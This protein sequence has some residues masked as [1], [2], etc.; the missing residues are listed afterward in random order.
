M[1]LFFLPC[2]A[3]TENSGKNSLEVI[4]GF[5][6]ETGRYILVS[7]W[8]G[9]CIITSPGEITAALGDCGKVLPVKYIREQK[10][11]TNDD[12]RQTMY[13]FENT[14]GY[15]F[16]VIKG[17]AIPNN[18]YFLARNGSINEQ[19]VVKIQS[20]NASAV[21]SRIKDMIEKIKKRKIKNAWNLVRFDAGGPA[22]ICL[23]EF[24]GDGVNLL[25]SIVLVQHDKIAFKDYPA[26][27]IGETEAWRADDGGV[28]SPDMFSILF[29]ARSK[30]GLLFG[31]CWAGP[32][33]E[34]E[35]VLTESGEKLKENGGWYRYWS[36][37]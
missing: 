8:G 33:G 24:Q 14:S 5:A 29:I 26:K 18:T 25:A 12:A 11:G 13:N 31:L 16:E 6:D 37:P 7:P 17:S 36:P 34:N 2:F 15:L 4:F 3:R 30:S 22:M 19:S 23:V 27:L 28:I 21:T 20:T 32:E 35:T 10:A 9:A 1:V